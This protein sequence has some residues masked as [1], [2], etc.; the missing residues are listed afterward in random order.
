VIEV[1]VPGWRRLQLS[2]LVLDMNGVLSLDGKLL[3]SVPAR[4]AAL[5]PLVDIH[6][7]SADTHGTLERI[8]EALRVTGSRVEPGKDE[9]AQKAA[10]VRSRTPEKT[11][12]IGNGANDVGM[13][14]AAAVG[15]SVLGHEG[16]FPA[17]L[18]A[19][20]VLVGSVHEA[21]DLL[22]HPT[23]LVATLRR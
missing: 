14:K 17:A 7:L 3:P 21:L 23:R 6:L 1:E 9:A 8:A 16:L 10:F 13:L 22:L 5:R 11:V 20:D 18:V 15:I 19:S 2:L 12:A 4:I